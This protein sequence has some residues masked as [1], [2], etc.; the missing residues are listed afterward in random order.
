[1][2]IGY[3]MKHWFLSREETRDEA[4][5]PVLRTR[6]YR[7]KPEHV[8]QVLEEA[9]S[10]LLPGWHIT[11]VDKKRGELVVERRSL[12]GTY[13][14]MVTVYRL[15]PLRAAVDVVVSRRGALGDFGY[16]Y[17]VIDTLYRGLGKVL[18]EMDERR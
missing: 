12:V 8:I 6:Y 18:K 9:L 5:D 2:R 14:M 4:H 15:S 1:M 10:T 11:H 13:D 17:R 16:A 7:E 3:W